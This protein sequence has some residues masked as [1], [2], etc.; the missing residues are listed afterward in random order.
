MKKLISILIGLT[1]IFGSCHKNEKETTEN[2]FNVT[3]IGQGPDCGNAYLIR[4]N[5]DIPGIPENSFDNTFYEINLP[6][7]SKIDGKKISIEFREPE[8]GELMSCATRGIDYPQVY[9]TKVE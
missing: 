2:S 9:I 1:F 5:S 7:E 8:N 6:D 3:V 4:F